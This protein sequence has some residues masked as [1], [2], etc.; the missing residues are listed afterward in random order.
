MGR[1]RKVEVKT[2]G[3]ASF[4]NLTPIPPCG[5]GLWFYLMTGP[6]TTAIPGLF[7]AG[8]ATMAEDLD[9]EPEAFREAF[10]E[11]LSEGMVKADFKAKL[12]FL[13][14]AIEYNK[15]ESPNVVKSW[16]NEFEILPECELKIEAYE[17]L[18]AFIC[19]L[20][21]AFAKAF[22]ES[23]V[24]PSFKPS[25][26]PSPKAIANQ[27]QEQEQKQEQEQREISSS[28]KKFTDDDMRCAE[29]IFKGVI[30]VAEKTKKPNFEKW[31]DV[32]RLMREQ[33]G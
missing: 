17:T 33:D 4:K 16:A 29:F 15:P 13:P 28:E 30:S 20:S 22:S 12:V 26:K 25:A 19:G 2:W 5:Q 3:D 21:E 31:A 23:F 1:Y 10:R 6:R 7:A 11:A 27:E 18:E 24:K 8:P 9:W 32:I 14:K